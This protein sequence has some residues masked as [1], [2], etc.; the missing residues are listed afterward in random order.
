MSVILELVSAHG[1]AT[2]L[3]GQP[4]PLTAVLGAGVLVI[5]G[6]SAPWSQKLSMPVS[7][8][9]VG[10]T[11][12]SAQEGWLTDCWAAAEEAAAHVALQ[13]PCLRVLQ[14]ASCLCAC[15]GVCTQ[16][17]TALPGARVLGPKDRA[18]AQRT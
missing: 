4:L 1:A 12:M 6:T 7:S 18:A 11:P 14:C 8:C 16:H 13:A 5:V 10:Q 9:V 17:T 3:P 15:V 2:L